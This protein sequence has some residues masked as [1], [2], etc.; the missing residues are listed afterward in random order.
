MFPPVFPIHTIRRSD[1][2]FAGRDSAVIL[3]S[4]TDSA[5]AMQA[6]QRLRTS[7]AE[8]SGICFAVSS[9]PLDGQTA[10][11]LLAVLEGRL[12]KA[13]ALGQGAVVASG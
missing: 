12:T 5:G 1:Q 2:V 8:T 4:E 11:Q 10:P 7:L 13:K 9:Y 3:M 6:V